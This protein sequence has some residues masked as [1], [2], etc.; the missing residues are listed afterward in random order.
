M[1]R[2]IYFLKIICI[3]LK[4]CDFF[5]CKEANN[6]LLDRYFNV[7]KYMNCVLVYFINI[8]N[9]TY[10]GTLVVF[11]ICLMISDVSWGVVFFLNLDFIRK[12]I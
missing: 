10:R 12:F 7:L 8:L 9:M 4:K 1:E 6:C 5:F 2:I 11:F 3:W